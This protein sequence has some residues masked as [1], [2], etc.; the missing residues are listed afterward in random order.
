MA[1]EEVAGEMEG[2]IWL[3]GEF[4]GGDLRLDGNGIGGSCRGEGKGSDAGVGG[5]KSK[6]RHGQEAEDFGHPNTRNERACLEYA[7]HAAQEPSTGH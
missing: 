3:Q 4:R 1:D 6:R 2:T 5:G 7:I